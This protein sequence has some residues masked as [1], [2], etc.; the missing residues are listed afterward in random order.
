MRESKDGSDTTPDMQCPLTALPVPDLPAEACALG[1]LGATTAGAAAA[2]RYSPRLEALPSVAGTNPG[3]LPL[4]ELFSGARFPQQ[5]E[6]AAALL[7]IPQAPAAAQYPRPQQQQQQQQQQL[8]PGAGLAVLLVPYP[9]STPS[10]PGPTGPPLTFQPSK[11]GLQ[12]PWAAELSADASPFRSAAALPF[13]GPDPPMAAVPAPPPQ[14]QMQVPLAW[15]C[16]GELV[17]VQPPRARP[18]VSLGKGRLPRRQC[19]CHGTL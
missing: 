4:L 9:L 7:A 2:A 17:S 15:G 13:P 16:L 14:A 8:V 10:S 18:N 6:P 11:E 3:S 19:S 1:Q 12:S 5:Q